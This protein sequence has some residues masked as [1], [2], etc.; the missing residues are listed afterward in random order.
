MGGVRHPAQ[1]HANA[2]GSSAGGALARLLRHRAGL[3]EERR[4]VHSIDETGVGVVI[5][6][7]S[8]MVSVCA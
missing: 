7:G 1:P 5:Q 8:K 6:T 4:P 2:A 3:H